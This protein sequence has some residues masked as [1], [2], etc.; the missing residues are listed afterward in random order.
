MARPGDYACQR[1]D[2]VCIAADRLLIALEDG[3]NLLSG[4]PEQLQRAVRVIERA[5]AIHREKSE[6]EYR[7]Y[8]EKAR[9]A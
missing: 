9:A 7:K 3:G 1:V 2:E 4:Y 5:L 6:A 8:L